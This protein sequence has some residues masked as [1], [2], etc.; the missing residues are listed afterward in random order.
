[1]FH[2]FAGAAA[3]PAAPAAPSSGPSPMILG[4]MKIAS[5]MY[6]QYL[7]KKLWF[8]SAA[9][10][11]VSGVFSL[12]SSPIELY[13]N[14][15]KIGLAP[16]TIYCTEALVVKASKCLV[17]KMRLLRGFFSIDARKLIS[18]IS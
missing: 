16:S 1:M 18:W 15:V 9:C 17:V 14:L 3:P 4:K 8:S 10:F 12:S 5:S 13:L 11:S 7:L 6:S 2:F